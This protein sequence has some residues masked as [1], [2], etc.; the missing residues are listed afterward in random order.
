MSEAR[1]ETPQAQ[2]TGLALLRLPLG[3]AEYRS[4][5][6]PFSYNEML[7]S[8][9]MKLSVKEEPEPRKIAPILSTSSTQWT[10]TEQQV[11][12]GADILL[13]IGCH[14]YAFVSA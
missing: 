10:S 4:Q 11:M 14:M 3:E 7:S 13:Y 1:K 9:P 2:R 6:P 8:E 5:W 12:R